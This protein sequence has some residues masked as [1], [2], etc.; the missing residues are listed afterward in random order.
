LITK[1][2]I[3][4]AFHKSRHELMSF[5]RC[6]CIDKGYN[7]FDIFFYL[8]SPFIVLYFDQSTKRKF[9]WCVP[10]QHL[11]GGDTLTWCDA[12][13]SLSKCKPH[14]KQHPCVEMGEY[15]VHYRGKEHVLIIKLNYLSIT[16]YLNANIKVM[17]LVRFQIKGKMFCNL[18]QQN[19]G[20][21]YGNYTTNCL[22][23]SAVA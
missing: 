3:D 6:D 21:C 8:L 5:T 7:A 9:Q 10:T 4:K 11:K 22:S 16:P 23:W 13:S 18:A 14:I 19:V 15:L 1:Q 20:L 17:Y 12:T 2:Y